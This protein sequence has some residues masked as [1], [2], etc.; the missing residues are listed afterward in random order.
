MSMCMIE[1]GE[2]NEVINGTWSLW[3]IGLVR[4]C[5]AAW[6]ASWGAAVPRGHRGSA[7]APACCSS[8]GARDVRDRRA[9]LCSWMPAAQLDARSATGSRLRHTVCALHGSP[10]PQWGGRKPE[11][12][13]DQ[14]QL[15]GRMSPG[16]D[17]QRSTDV[18]DV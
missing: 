13:G 15:V 2:E 18:Y 7:P 3:L 9:S 8:R 12:S 14:L 17:C 11:P 16:A 5:R 10:A 1:R 6:L 4:G